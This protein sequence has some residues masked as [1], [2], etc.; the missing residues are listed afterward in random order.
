MTTVEI[1]HRHARILDYL[2]TVRNLVRLD[3][4]SPAEALVSSAS[5]FIGFP[6]IRADFTK[7][8]P[9]ERGNSR[10][11]FDCSGFFNFLLKSNKVDI[12]V[13][14]LGREARFAREFFDH[15]GTFVEFGQHK[16]AD[17]VFFSYD[18]AMPTHMALYVGD[19]K[20]IHKG[21]V[22]LSLIPMEPTGNYR[23]RIILS[24]LDVVANDR[25]NAGNPIT[26]RAN[27]GA[28]R[29]YRNPIGFRRV[30]EC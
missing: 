11:G 22:D 5:E 2:P 29:Y 19:N 9:F 26:Y 30:V 23:K 16:R 28:Q 14:Q 27:R 6:A 8:S 13:P 3:Q 24:D 10:E 17:L 21:F 7:D 20:I 12:F 25:R 1:S 18:G 15:I 4:K